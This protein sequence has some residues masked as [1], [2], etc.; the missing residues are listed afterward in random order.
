MPGMTLSL[1]WLCPANA[2]LSMRD[3]S[4]SLSLCLCPKNTQQRGLNWNYVEKEF[5]FDRR[6]HILAVEILK[7]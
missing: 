5:W 3:C 2:S 6:K 4:C 7:Y 1:A